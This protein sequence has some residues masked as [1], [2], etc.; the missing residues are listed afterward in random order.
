MRLIFNILAFVFIT[1]CTGFE[2]AKTHLAEADDFAISV[3]Y[4]LEYQPDTTRPNRKKE[5]FLLLV[6]PS[7]SIF[8]SEHVYLRDSIIALINS[9]KSD[10]SAQEL[11]SYT[12][13]LNSDFDFRIDKKACNQQTIFDR[14]YHTIF[15]YPDLLA[16]LPWRIMPDTMT[17]SGVKCQRAEL[18]AFGRRW[19]GWFSDAIPISDGPFRFCGLP[20][21]LVDVYDGNNQFH[22][23][24]IAISKQPRKYSFADLEDVVETK[25]TDFLRKRKQYRENPIGVAESS[26]VTFVQGRSEIAKRATTKINEFNNFIER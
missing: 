19:I 13:R 16:E 18:T 6:N 17:L 23:S 9:G 12:R 7:H 11:L 10:K 8:L 24:M 15:R 22:F 5:G 20:G 14:V 25:R 3:T 2:P 21:L 4:D 26:G 1:V